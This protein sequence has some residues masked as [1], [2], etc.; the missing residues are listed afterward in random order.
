M[1]YRIERHRGASG[2]GN[3]EQ[4]QSRARSSPGSSAYRKCSRDSENPAGEDWKA[5]GTR[6]GHYETG[7]GAEYPGGKDRRDA[8]GAET[9]TTRFGG[10]K[11]C[12]NYTIRARKLAQVAVSIVRHHVKPRS[13]SPT[14]SQHSGNDSEQNLITLCTACH[15]TAHHR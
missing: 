12:K 4:T 9:L 6:C 14:V 3:T 8:V 15:A 13:P 1:L 7:D 5:S 2:Y 11:G 10:R